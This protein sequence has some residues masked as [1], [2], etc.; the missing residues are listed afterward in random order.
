MNPYR[1][2]EKLKMVVR[3]QKWTQAKFSEAIIACHEN[4]QNSQAI[5][6]YELKAI[7]AKLLE[8]EELFR[9]SRWHEKEFTDAISELHA[10][11]ED[12]R[13]LWPDSST[14]PTETYARL[15]SLSF[16]E[17]DENCEQ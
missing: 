1:L 15:V 13:Q 3:S 11:Y 6:I 5:Y 9:Q 7:S 8:A 16:F 17:S 2:I 12:Y 4:L 14:D 10:M